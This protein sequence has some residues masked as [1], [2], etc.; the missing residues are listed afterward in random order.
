MNENNTLNLTKVKGEVFQKLH[1]WDVDS[2][3]EVEPSSRAHAQLLA[4]QDCSV[5]EFEI[6]ITLSN[7]KGVVPVTFQ[8]KKVDISFVVFI[9]D[10]QKAFQLVEEG[11][12][13]F[14]KDKMCVELVEEKWLDKAGVEHSTSHP[15]IIT[16]GTCVCLSWTDQKVDIKTSPL[17]MDESTSDGDHNMNKTPVND[18]EEDPSVD[19]F[20]MV[21]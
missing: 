18:T 15:Q 16:R 1:T 8:H 17:S 10:F 3:V 11:G 20:V 5:V 2:Q 4:R 7:P 6:Q 13:L 21:D 14:Q 19:S 9:E 12:V